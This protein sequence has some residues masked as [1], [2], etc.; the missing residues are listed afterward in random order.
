MRLYAPLMA[1]LLLAAGLAHAQDANTRPFDSTV[2]LPSV[3]LSL[4]EMNQP[5]KPS[6]VV[7]KPAQ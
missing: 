1:G 7:A 3:P 5:T 6:D 4:H 2:V